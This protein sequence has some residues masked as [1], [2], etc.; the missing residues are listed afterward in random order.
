MTNPKLTSPVMDTPVEPSMINREL[1]LLNF[2]RRVLEL[3]V[4]ESIPLLE[5]LRYLCISSS[6]LDEAF[7]VRVASLVQQVHLGVG[8]VGECGMTPP[9]QLE[10]VLA[11]AHLLVADQYRVLNEVLIPAMRDAGI[12]F[13]RRTHWSKRQA[14][15]VRDYFLQELA[16]VLTPLG[17]DPAH[18]FPRVLNKSL[19]F[20]ITLEGLDDF[21]RETNMAVVQA[22]R[23]L[24]RIVPM[25]QTVGGGAHDF[26]FLSS[27]IHAHVDE[28]F[29]GMKVTGCF[30]FRVTRNSD[31]LV[32]VDLDEDL[33]QVLQ[34]GLFERNYGGAVRLE[35]ADNCPDDVAD[36]LLEKFDLTRREMF[37]VHGPVN[38][39]RLTAVFDLV[40]CAEFKFAPFTPG[41]PRELHGVEDIFAAITKHRR[42]LIHHPYQS[43]TP[44][45]DFIRQAANDP[46]VVAIKQTLY[47]T[48]KNSA[49]VDALEMAARNGKEVTAVIELR[50]RFDEAANIELATRLQKAGAYVAYGIVGF[51]THAKMLMV[52]RREGH[53]MKRF[54]HL[55]TGNY[56]AG[57]ARV[58][59][60]YGVFTDD[61][62][63]CEDV[64]KLFVQLT[65]LSRGIRLKKLLQSPFTLRE[66]MIERIQREA[67]HARAGKPALIRAKMNS[68]IDSSIIHALYA[69][70]QAGVKVEL[71]I[72]GICSLR[73]GVPG[74]SE[75]IKVRSLMGRFL[76]HA[77][78]FSFLNDGQTELYISSADW[79]PRNLYSRVETCVPIE[80]KA[81]RT[82][83]NEEVFDLAFAD[84]V[85]SWELQT[86]GE[87]V[88]VRPSEGEALCSA[89]AILLARMEHKE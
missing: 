47:R 87:Y 44:V 31:L 15:W 76:E 29:P 52:V 68:L 20:V 71:V 1:S 12:H 40:D 62:M 79:M 42:I 73:P 60:D 13:A 83:I 53:E 56:H 46:K 88:R 59:T 67:E 84:N 55:G 81:L 38:L 57:T 45:V 41:I 82:R 65:G 86:S 2:N 3:A 72:R 19:N 34:G 69:A 43:F 48:G 85:G 10:R 64:H 25:P 16:P 6:N 11:E 36:Y 75:N 14:D 26:V 35:V 78:V 50:A 63:I 54:V 49:I 58:Y 24:P 4:D 23:S 28:L 37:K 39:S 51:K 17:L 32:D 7:E 8:G 77:R 74:L 80:E 5:R 27:M 21:G 18:P 66:G 22:P 61:R 70:S 33:L 9:E 30:Q 89:H